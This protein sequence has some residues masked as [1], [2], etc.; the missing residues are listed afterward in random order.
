[1]VVRFHDGGCM[2]IG[3]YNEFMAMLDDGHSAGWEDEIESVAYLY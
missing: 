1:M 3:H 2:L